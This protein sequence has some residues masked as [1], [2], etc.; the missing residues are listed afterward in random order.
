MVSI[1]AISRA[2]PARQTPAWLFLA[3]GLLAAGAPA[4]A[5]APA[6]AQAPPA[7]P[8]P[9]P[10]AVQSGPDSALVHK[11][12]WSAL[13][14]L[15]HANRTGNYSV[16]RDLGAPSFQERNSAATL[17]QIFEQFRAQQI[18]VGNVLIVNPAFSFPPAITN[19]L[20]H[21]RGTFPLRPTGIEFEM[22]F[23]NVGGQWRIF[24]LAARPLAPA[25][26][27]RR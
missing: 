27:P 17:A 7:R 13:A 11:L 23:Q 16:L 10:P 14:A 5:Q 21:V 15:D 9:A 12:I 18:D 1:G 25:G 19:G 20:L 26:Q 22:L 4:G 24:G 8:T 3:A 6:A 2:R